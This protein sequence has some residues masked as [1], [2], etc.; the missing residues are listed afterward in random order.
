MIASNTIKKLSW[1]STACAGVSEC[2]S[3]LLQSRERRAVP[4][5]LPAL[6][7]CKD[8][9]GGLVAVIQVQK[10]KASFM[11]AQAPQEVVVQVQAAVMQAQRVA[12]ASVTINKDKP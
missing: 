11:Q 6:N 4:A 1:P 10:Q 5:K 2:D 7:T 9:Y 8:M 12:T 3:E